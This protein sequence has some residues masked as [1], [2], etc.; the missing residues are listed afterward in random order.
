MEIPQRAR[1]IIKSFDLKSHPEGGFYYETYRSPES[2]PGK[3]RQLLTSIY[4]LITGNSCSNLHRIQSDECWYFHEGSTLLV[5]S[6]F[7]DGKHEITELGLNMEQGEVPFHVVP[8]KTIFGSHLKGDKG[9]AFVSCAVAPGFD[10]ADF[11]LF[12]SEDL[13]NT[14]PQHRAIIEKLT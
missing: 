5:H 7:P 11:E 14:Y 8:A 3:N 9:Y 6:L 10:F 13:L 1:E 4:F 2:I 12:A